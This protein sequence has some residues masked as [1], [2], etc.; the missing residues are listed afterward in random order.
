MGNG[1]PDK[2]DFLSSNQC[3]LTLLSHGLKSLDE[4]K[5][6][7]NGASEIKVACTIFINSLAALQE[8][9]NL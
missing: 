4:Y 2:Y 5:L 8:E 6:A 1:A 3:L 7:L 9:V